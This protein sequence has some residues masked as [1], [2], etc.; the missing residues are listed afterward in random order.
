MLLYVTRWKV[1]VIMQPKFQQSLPIDRQWMVLFPFIDKVLDIAG[2][3]QRQI[4]TVYFVQK[5]GE[6]TAQFLDVVVTVSVVANDRNEWVQ[7]VQKRSGSAASTFLVVVDVAVSMRRQVLVVLGGVSDQSI[8]KVVDCVC[9]VFSSVS[10]I[11]RFLRK[12]A[13]AHFSAL[14][15]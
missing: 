8:D 13:R 11:F 9:V 14:E 1:L 15:L 7:T 6:S 3:L 2:M 4:R 12:E 5:T 10:R